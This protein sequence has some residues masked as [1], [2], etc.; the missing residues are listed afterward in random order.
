MLTHDAEA[1][2]KATLAAMHVG[3]ATVCVIV[4]TRRSPTS[5]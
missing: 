2:A 3:T 1:A 4:F 5:R